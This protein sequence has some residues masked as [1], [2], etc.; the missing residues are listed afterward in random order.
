MIEDI[1]GNKNA[2]RVLLHVFHYGEIHAAGVAN[3]YGCSI[4]PIQNQLE[5]FEG[6]GILV[7]KLMGRSRVYRF[8]PKSPYLVPV[9]KIIEIAYESIPLP[10]REKIFGTR[11]R[12]RAKGKVIL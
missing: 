6:A 2:E 3:D 10:E 5:R 9:K 12:P 11:R 7:S 4:S 1:F 8:N